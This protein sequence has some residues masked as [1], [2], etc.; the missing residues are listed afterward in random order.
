LLEDPTDLPQ[1]DPAMNF[2]ENEMS[3]N[4]WVYEGDLASVY[5]HGWG[6]WAGLTRV[7]GQ[8]DGQPVRAFETWATLSNMLYQ[9]E[10]SEAKAGAKTRLDLSEPRQFRNVKDA[11]PTQQKKL[12]AETSSDGDTQIFVS[13]AYNPPAAKHAI[14]NKLFLQSTLDRLLK[15]GYT[16][17]PNFPANAVVVKPVYKII[18]QN[19][20]GGIYT[21]PGWPGT[22]DPAVA[23]G[24]SRW[25]ACVYVDI[26]GTGAGGSSIDKGCQGRKAD[27][28]FHVNNFIHQKI[29]AADAR[30]L[31][32]QLGLKV[33]EGDYAILVGM[34][35]ATRET[36]RW[37][38]QTFWWSADPNQPPSPSSQAIAQYRPDSSL[39]AAAQHYAMSVTYAMVDPPQPITGGKNV[40]QPVIGYNP[41]LEAGFDPATFQISRPINGKIRNEYGVQTN[42]MSCHGLAAY[43]PK[44][45]YAD[46]AANREKPYAADF[47]LDLNNPLFNG[48]LKLDFAWSILGALVLDSQ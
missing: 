46:P 6:L 5:R 2:P 40:G 34:H 1:A 18:P 37:T 31:S 30:Y 20:P 15:D 26:N 22:P 12:S 25:D 21:F 36:K 14:A 32:N 44:V 29:T 35:V 19:T 11:A 45:N 4:G 28:T 39:D 41:H 38:W 42:C 47:Y 48:K 9:M 10:V 43:D 13:V 16:A 3:V 24:E 23:F 17:I 7:M 8:V 33:A 27:N